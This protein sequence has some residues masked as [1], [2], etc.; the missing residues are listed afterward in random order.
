M[1]HLIQAREQKEGGRNERKHQCTQADNKQEEQR[2]V[3]EKEV[4]SEQADCYQKANTTD[5]RLS[6]TENKKEWIEKDCFEDLLEGLDD[7]DDFLDEA[8]LV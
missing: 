7:D 6:V 4:I 2:V 3:I 5:E 1:L 8:L